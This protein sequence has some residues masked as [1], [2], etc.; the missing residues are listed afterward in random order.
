MAA[1]G[2]HLR[3]FLSNLNAM[4]GR[5]ELIFTQLRIPLF[6]IEDVSDAEYRLYYTSERSGL[7]PMVLGLV[8]GLAK[9][10]HQSIDIVQIHSKTDVNDEDIFSV[11]HL[12]D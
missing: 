11:R 10:F 12:P 8:K 7:A 2:S 6:R 3:E 5:V 4:H 1:G 9:R